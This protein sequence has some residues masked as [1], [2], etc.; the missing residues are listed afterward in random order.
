MADYLRVISW[1]LRN[2]KR[3][4]IEVEEIQSTKHFL[5]QLH[6]LRVSA[7]LDGQEIVGRSVAESPEKALFIATCEF[8]ERYIV[9]EFD[10][11]P[12][13]G[14][15]IHSNPVMAATNAAYELKERDAIL[16]HLFMG[17]PFK[18][19]PL[20]SSE[21]DFGIS[22]LN[23]FLESH[24]TKIEIFSSLLDRA[25]PFITLC[26]A[27]NS[28]CRQIF[29][30]G[31]DITFELSIRKSF[32]ELIQNLPVILDMEFKT[33]TSLA[34]FQSKEL[35]QPS[36]HGFLALD[37]NYSKIIE[38]LFSDEPLVF[39]G[40][41][42]PENFT[43]QTFVSKTLGSDLGLHLVRA[44]SEDLQDYFVGKTELKKINLRRIS[45]IDPSFDHRHL[46]LIPHF[47]G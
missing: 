19:I 17:I 26:R 13:S 47:I 33:R 7:Q 15:A 24:N 41:C 2:R 36:D 31:S 35:F 9:H 45:T 40:S 11:Y 14:I 20:Q 5:G 37:S 3:Y 23:N 6:D 28:Q 39:D 29:G 21:P 1:L 27:K 38:H 4:G 32:F 8:I 42:Q 30:F 22:K 12:G 43:F 44:R 46:Q 34:S 18:R 10:L 16:V 25:P